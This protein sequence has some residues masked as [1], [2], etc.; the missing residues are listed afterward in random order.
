[1]VLTAIVILN[2]NLEP[3]MPIDAWHSIYDEGQQC[4]SSIYPHW[5]NLLC[6]QADT[7]AADIQEAL[8]KKKKRTFR[9][10]TYRGVDLDQLLDMSK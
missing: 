4:W 7:E 9:K 5:F 10:Y 8:E 2:H 3:W 1:M 6:V